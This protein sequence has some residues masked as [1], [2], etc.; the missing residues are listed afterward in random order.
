MEAEDGGRYEVSACTALARQRAHLASFCKNRF[1][2]QHHQTGLQSQ[3]ILGLAPSDYSQ[4]VPEHLTGVLITT[5][6]K[7]MFHH[8]RLMI[9]Q[10]NITTE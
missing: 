8:T 3:R 9:A 6:V 2:R 1:G 7:E 4:S 5:A 10:Q